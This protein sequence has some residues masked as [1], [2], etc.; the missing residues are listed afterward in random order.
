MKKIVSTLVGVLALALA[1]QFASG[2]APDSAKDFVADAIKGDNSEIMMGQLAE[3]H[4]GSQGVRAFGQTLVT[5][6]GKAKADMVK[7]AASMNVTP[8]ADPKPEAKKEYDRLAKL[9]GAEFDRE[10][11]KGMVEDHRKD[12][13]AFEKEAK[14]GHAASKIAADQLPTLKKHLEMAENLEKH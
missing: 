2:A 11:I 10:F 9:S 5:D 7:L 6:H 4:G 14:A 3:Q 12:V 8:S 13:A 1:P